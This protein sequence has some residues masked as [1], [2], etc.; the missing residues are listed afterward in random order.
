VS[1]LATINVPG[2]LPMDDDPPVF[3]TAIE[4]W[5][6]LAEERMRAEE[7]F[8]ITEDEPY[9][10]TVDTLDTLGTDS[11]WTYRDLAWLTERGIARDGTGSIWGETPGYDGV[12]DLGL[13]YTV[14]IV[15]EGTE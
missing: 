5:A 1:F 13:A 4:A 8:P 6:W 11:T 10:T 2:Y 15:E 7:D 9:S 14:S 3:D 12:H